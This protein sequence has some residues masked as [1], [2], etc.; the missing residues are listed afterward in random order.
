MNRIVAKV[1]TITAKDSLH[2]VECHTQ[3]N[4]QLY[5]LTL[6]LPHTLT[7]GDTISLYIK[8]TAITLSLE[9]STHLSFANELTTTVEGIEKGDIVSMV[10]LRFEKQ[11]LEVMV[12]RRICDTLAIK[13]GDTLYALLHASDI[14]ISQ[15][16]V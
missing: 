12:L 15:E 16:V 7:Q 14:S 5:I 4:T 8:A 11:L 2:L 9:S 10:T 1:A 13:T 3:A 6:E